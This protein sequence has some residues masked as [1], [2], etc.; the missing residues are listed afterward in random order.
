MA[1]PQL[2]FEKCKVFLGKPEEDAL[3]W[4]TRYCDIGQYNR[5]GVAELRANFQMYLD[6]AAR[7]WFLCLPNKP[8]E[9]EDVAATAG[10]PATAAI[11]GLRTRFYSTFQETRLR[12]RVQGL[13]EGFTAYFYDV[14]DL[15]RVVDPIMP[16][17]MKLD[18]LFLGLK[19]TL[20][21]KLYPLRL[22][23]T[24]EFF[25]M[26]KVHAEATTLANRRDW[27]VAA[28]SSEETEP[29][30]NRSVMA[31]GE[32]IPQT[33]ATSPNY[34]ELLKI[35]TGIQGELDILRAKA[36]GPARSVGYRPDSRECF[37]CK[38]TGHLKA[39]CFLNPESSSY[40]GKPLAPPNVIR[41]IP[42]RPEENTNFDHPISILASCGPS[43]PQG[44]DQTRSEKSHTVLK[45]DFSRMIWERVTVFSSVTSTPVQAVIDTGAAVSVITPE[46]C[47]SL[48]MVPKPW[49][50]PSLVMAN[51]SPATPLGAVH[52]IVSNPRG[53]AEGS[54]IVIEM[55]GMTLLL[56]N[57]LL[58][59]FG[60]LEI[61]YRNQSP[62][63]T[64]GE[65]PL[66]NIQIE[67]DAGVVLEGRQP[68]FSVTPRMIPAQSRASVQILP[69]RAIGGHWLLEPSNQLMA[70]KALSVGRSLFPEGT[71]SSVFVTNFSTQDEWL[72][73]GVTLGDFQQVET[74]AEM[75][76][77]INQLPTIS[78]ARF[79]ERVSKER[80]TEEKEEVVALLMEFQDCFART[81]DELGQCKL[82]QHR[83]DTGEAKPIHQQPYK[84][85]WKER[86][87]TDKQVR[88]MLANDI[89]E[90]SASPWSSPVVLVKKKGWRM[91]ILRG[92]SAFE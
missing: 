22:R 6:G 62:L 49:T 56:G 82:F 80:S 34:A 55:D 51:G 91:A 73:E 50:G 39:N 65:V 67:L 19:P 13:N 41:S 9:W 90:P 89:I 57:D 86:E 47:T 66:N 77:E 59:Q 52:L 79:A 83:I 3:D 36:T 69:L 10:P 1:R 45:I 11:P 27:A 12:A 7:Q 17:S 4:V 61:D 85:A 16:E 81:E 5:W 87:I 37:Q 25:S 26:G 54:V 20:L 78:R 33:K 2:K 23:T 70:S 28:L 38:K 64:L 43:N 32:M 92:F 21:E 42:A 29:S 71:H 63:I 24:A 53:R 84:S 14:L 35:V 75:A 31:M 88:S 46:L 72:G 74:V 40:K 68:I 76:P 58:K 44:R 60:R 8:V 30:Y 18:Y 15:C 48:A